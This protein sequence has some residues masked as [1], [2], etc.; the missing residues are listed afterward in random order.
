MVYK[1]G[2]VLFNLVYKLQ[3]GS[4]LEV[5]VVTVKGLISV[6]ESLKTLVVYY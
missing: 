6:I 2:K 4:Y 3:E 1:N 5:K